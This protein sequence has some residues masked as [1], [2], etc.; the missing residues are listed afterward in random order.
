MTWNRDAARQQYNIAGWSAGYFDVGDSGHLLVVPQGR[1]D[2]PVV[3]LHA[4]AHAVRDAGLSWPV[5]LRF[6]DILH[7]QLD[8]LCAAFASAIETEQYTAGY[9]AML[10]I[11]GL[12]D[13]GVTPDAG[14]ILVTGAAGGV[15][16]VAVSLLARLGYEVHAATGRPE[17]AGDFL[18]GLG[19]AELVL[20][21]DLAREVLEATGGEVVDLAARPDG[22]A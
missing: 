21:E 13:G 8:R 15:G 12:Q 1:P 22:A 9:T 16:S 3:D 5:L 2:T 7:E 18:R 17:V 14:P 11:L 6:T 20:R 19:A 4:L 10:C